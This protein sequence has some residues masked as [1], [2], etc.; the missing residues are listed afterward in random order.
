M[1]STDRGTV[2]QRYQYA[3]GYCGVHEEDAG[4]RLTIDHYKPQ[5]KGGSD[6]LDNLVYCCSACNSFK[7]DFWAEQSEEERILHPLLDNLALHFQENAEY[8]LEALTPTGTFHIETLHLNRP[9]LIAYRRKRVR[10]KEIESLI[11]EQE[12]IIQLLLTKMDTME[13]TTEQ[14]LL[15][16]KALS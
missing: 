15:R 2:R 14:L 8:L 9:E 1:R 4:A 5:V 13:A 7:V 16:L 6:D 3:C 11:L 12:Q 10:Q